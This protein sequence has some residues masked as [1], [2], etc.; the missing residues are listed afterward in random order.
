M[1][2][3]VNEVPLVGPRGRRELLERINELEEKIEEMSG[4]G[5][6]IKPIILTELPT[7]GDTIETLASKGLT[8]DEIRAAAEGNRTAVV[9]K[10]HEG[11][12]RY[13]ITEAMVSNDEIKFAFEY[14]ERAADMTLGTGSSVT[15]IMDLTD[16]SVTVTLAEF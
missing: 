5:E 8:I 9:Y 6:E 10:E 1:K 13:Y 2:T 16:M 7:R 15:I 3:K 11:T 4:S 14:T 12:V